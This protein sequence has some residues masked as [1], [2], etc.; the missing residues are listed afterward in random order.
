[1]GWDRCPWKKGSGFKIYLMLIFILLQLSAPLKNPDSYR[2]YR[3]HG[4]A[5][6][7]AVRDNYRE[8]LD[9]MRRL[10]PPVHQQCRVCKHMLAEFR[11]HYAGCGEF[12]MAQAVS[13]CYERAM[14]LCSSECGGVDNQCALCMEIRCCRGGKTGSAYIPDSHAVL[15]CQR[16]VFEIMDACYLNTASG[17]RDVCSFEEELSRAISVMENCSEKMKRMVDMAASHL[18]EGLS[19]GKRIEIRKEF[20]TSADAVFD[21]FDTCERERDS[22]ESLSED[23]VEM[24][25]DGLLQDLVVNRTLQVNSTMVEYTSGCTGL[26]DFN[27]RYLSEEGVIWDNMPERRAGWNKT[28]IEILKYLKGINFRDM[29]P[30][31]SF[32]TVRGTDRKN[33]QYLQN[34][35][36]TGIWCGYHGYITGYLGKRAVCQSYVRDHVQESFPLLYLQ[37]SGNTAHLWVTGYPV[38]SGSVC[39]ADRCIHGSMDSIYYVGSA[40]LPCV[41]SVDGG[42]IHSEV[43]CS[44]LLVAEELP[45]MIY[46][47]VLAHGYMISGRNHTV[48][49]SRVCNTAIY[50]NGMPAG[51]RMV[52]EFHG[53][54]TVVF[55]VDGGTWVIPE[56]VVCGTRMH[57]PL[58]FGRLR[59]IS[60]DEIRISLISY[61]SSDNPFH[62]SSGSILP[63][64]S[65]PLV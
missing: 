39:I 30:R 25:D 51:I 53:R 45:D 49:L 38:F 29:Y 62:I 48:E 11:S 18:F 52:D 50:L 4:L 64:Q 6:L 57:L 28:H 2:N 42:G 13:E 60:P 61:P 46:D 32:Y 36:W 40:A 17:M 56:I 1:M 35:I 44:E 5:Y 16:Q 47:D 19:A 43:G 21:D 22:A 58:P 65:S 3:D 14:E 15:Q 63:L 7:E 8:I 24:V 59:V 37:R 34:M 54:E 12:S 23:I 26:E 33:V 20:F 55:H 31:K 41:I 27:V 10:L 9:I